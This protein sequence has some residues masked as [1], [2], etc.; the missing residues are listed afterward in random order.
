[1][2]V[3]HFCNSSF[4]HVAPST[5]LHRAPRTPHP[6][7]RTPHPAPLHPCTPAPYLSNLLSGMNQIIATVKN[8]ASEIHAFTN[9]SPIAR[10]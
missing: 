6:A 3:E 10:M 5:L 9:D 1:M 2:K 4:K 8:S 7:P